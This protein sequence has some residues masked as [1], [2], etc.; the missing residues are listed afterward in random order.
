MDLTI[1]YFHA[2]KL[3]PQ[4]RKIHVG[5]FNA[6]QETCSVDSKEL[7]EASQLEQIVNAYKHLPF[8]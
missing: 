7:T 4:C 2:S 5:F 3:F 6:D 8:K 1:I